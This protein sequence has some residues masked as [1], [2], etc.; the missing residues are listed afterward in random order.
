VT[1]RLGI[2]AYV[3][4]PIRLRDGSLFGALCLIHHDPRPGLDRRDL[5]LVRLFAELVGHCLDADL[6]A[7]GLE[8]LGRLAVEQVLDRGGPSMVFQPIV[9]LATGRTVGVEA[10]SRFDRTPVDRPPDAWFAEAGRLGLG[11]ELEQVAA[12]SALAHLDAVPPHA[13]LSVNMSPEALCATDPDDLLGGADPTRVVVEITEHEAIE[14][15]TT[16]T[17]ALAQLRARG[18]RVAIDDVGTGY[19][20]LVQVVELEP[21]IVKLDGALTHHVDQDLGRQAMVDATVRY[22]RA[23]GTVLVAEGVETRR[24]LRTLRDIGVE[25]AQGYYLARPAPLEL[26]DLGRPG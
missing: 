12:R 20:A 18:V 8:P 1:Q 26:L 25:A 13:Y 11:P 5:R 24:E 19:A 10:L 17:D 2:A 23:T 14:E 15:P 7:G 4:A 3:G 16:V 9:E 21:D 22:T 6:P